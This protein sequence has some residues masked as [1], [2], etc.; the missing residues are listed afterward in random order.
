MKINF[1]LD[2]DSDP[3]V[4][5][6]MPVLDGRGASR[7]RKKWARQTSELVWSLAENPPEGKSDI[8][9]LARQ[10]EATA[11]L[12]PQKVPVHQVFLY[13][14]DPRRE[15]LNFLVHIDA[16]EGEVES[17]L[18]GLVQKDAAGAI[19][20][21]E[22]TDFNTE[23]LGR[24]MRSIRYFASSKAGTICCSVN[25]AWRVESK[26]IDLVVRTISENVGWVTANIDEF[27]SFARTL[28]VMKSFS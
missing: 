8:K 12:L 21:P 11:E 28:R 1:A 2:T 10:L 24:G 15:F 27:D 25:Y 4:W 13:M 6:G 14:P 5:L 20:D 16:S 9:E 18:E 23:H 26:G 22:V 7:E 17:T 3:T 19:R